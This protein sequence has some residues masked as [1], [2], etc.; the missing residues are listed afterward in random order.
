MNLILDGCPVTFEG[1]PTILEVARANGVY[2]PSLCDCPGLEPFAACRICLVEVKG[3]RGYVPACHTAA[4]EG[5]EVRTKS[6]EIETLRRGIL[7][8]ILAEH[9]NACLICAEKASCDEYKS[10]IR[11]AGEVTGCVLCP[12]N[13]RCE[14]QR[15]VESIGVE[16]VH[17]PSARREGDVRRDD[18]FIDRDNSLCILCGRCVRV[19]HE[20]RGASVLTFVA[21]GSETVIGTAMDRR[22]VESECRFCGACVDVCPTGSLS[23]RGV[24]YEPLPDAERAAVCP[25]CGQGCGLRVGLKD[26]RILGAVPDP[27]GPANRGQA[28]VKGRFLVRTAVNH[29][30]RLLRPM[31]RRNGRLGEATWEE[32]LTAAAGRL[33]EIGPGQTGVAFSAQSSC[34]DLFVLHR[35]AAE[36]LAAPAA[37]GS[38]AGSV[39]S[40]LRRL[41]RAAG[42]AAALGFRLA[43]IGKAKTIVLFGEDLPVTQPILGVEVNRAVRNGAVLVSVG[44]EGARHSRG[45]SIKVDVPAGGEAE[46]ISALTAVVRKGRG[47]S[48]GRARK[49]AKFRKQLAEI[50]RAIE[51][52]RPGLFL[53]GPALLKP[54]IARGTAAALW[55]LA[56]LAEGRI[57]ALDGEANLR[58]GHEISGAFPMK[59]LTGE[60]LCGAAA[61]RE[62]KALYVAGPVPKIEPGAAEL[63]IVQGSYEDE[64]TAVADIVFPE[65]TSFEADGLYVNVEGR[66]QHSRKVIEPRGEARPGWVILD[67]LAAKMGRPGFAYASPGEIRRDLTCAVP[68]FAGLTGDPIPP[69]GIFL[70]EE[71]AAAEGSMSAERSA[72]QA[73][74]PR[75][76]TLRD[77]DDYKGLNL[78][79]ENK[80][81]RLVRGR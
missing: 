6:P 13:G 53:F 38:W 73:A 37:A 74:G 32:A 40:E 28:C 62:V 48:P 70:P 80:S 76:T 46:F 19:C 71:E 14:L 3:R 18:P 25:L 56:A 39:V 49:T 63:V 77:P 51:N 59:T 7:E 1:H 78:A 2:I 47:G 5:L 15:V 58:G 31:V 60:E 12:V 68:A 44:L 21:R 66:A 36:I 35:F 24:R 30:R 69:E 72:E 26:G 29:S 9:P 16:R 4:E 52:G 67:G 79:R 50:A 41:G 65:T 22:L 8:L 61:R 55:D 54:G 27:E 75:L 64:A 33:S 23:E 11:K 42:G 20:I 81:L 43:D 45:A 17:F 34:E 10:T 57:I